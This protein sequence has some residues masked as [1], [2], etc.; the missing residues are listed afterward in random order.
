MPNGWVLLLMPAHKELDD[1]V[2]EV[3][4]FSAQRAS[5]ARRNPIGLLLVPKLPP[6]LEEE[7]SFYQVNPLDALD[8]PTIL[9]LPFFHPAVYVVRRLSVELFSQLTGKLN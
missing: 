2:V 8:H 5:T 6:K 3:I 7:V 4:L 1:I 9:M